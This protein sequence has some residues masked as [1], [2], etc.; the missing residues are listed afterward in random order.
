MILVPH[1]S[2][3]CLW[4]KGDNIQVLNWKGIITWE[5]G[6]WNMEHVLDEKGFIAEGNNNLEHGT[7]DLGKGNSNPL[8][9]GKANPKGTGNPSLEWRRITGKNGKDKTTRS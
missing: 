4:K 9:G 7:R 2:W 8:H 6:T 3:S 1:I 5:H